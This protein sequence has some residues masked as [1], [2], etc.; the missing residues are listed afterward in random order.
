MS[1]GYVYLLINP[2]MPGLLKVG[3]TF[4][5]S[6]ARAREL[7]STGVPTPFEVAFEL[8]SE[9]HEELEKKLHGH[10]SEF[11]VSG[12]RE[13]FRY[14]L[15]L[16]IQHLQE[17]SVPP[18]ELSSAYC[19]ESIF[20]DLSERYAPWLKP[21]IVDVRIVQTQERVWLE[22][23]EEEEIAG[24]LVDQTIKRSDLAF[25]SGDGHESKCFSPADSVSKNSAKFVERWCPYSI[26]MTT[27]LFHDSACR[28]IENDPNLNPHKRDS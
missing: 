21:S 23:T 2:S 14:P 13:F 9:N 22:I 17:L 4:R 1:A 19:A 20:Q 10:L 11:R 18:M 6:K 28:Q 8:F 5:D 3:R 26:I 16:A 7:H 12:N 15:R 24:Y 27:D 25:C